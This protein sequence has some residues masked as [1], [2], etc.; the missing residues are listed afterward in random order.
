MKIG[1]RDIE[2]MPL[3]PDHHF[4]ARVARC[5]NSTSHTYPLPFHPRNASRL[6]RRA[7]ARGG[8]LEPQEVP[9]GAPKTASSWERAPAVPPKK[10]YWKTVVL[11]VWLGAPAVCASN[12]DDNFYGSSYRSCSTLYIRG[13]H[14]TLQKS[15][16]TKRSTNVETDIKPRF[17]YKCASLVHQR[18]VCIRTTVL[19]YMLLFCRKSYRVIWYYFVTNA[20]MEFTRSLSSEAD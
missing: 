14:G 16:E 19:I 11:L 18:S 8:L 3:R 17:Y 2:L 7:A 1:C 6:A 20:C 15:Q 13:L 5:T 10:G 4:F 9:V 12:L